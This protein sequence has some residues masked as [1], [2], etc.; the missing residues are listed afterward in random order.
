MGQRQFKP[1]ET[2]ESV[3]V[4]QAVSRLD[5]DALGE[6][7][8][9]A[10]DHAGELAAF[11][12]GHTAA[13]L[14]A[15]RLASRRSRHATLECERLAAVFDVDPDSIRGADAMIASHLTPPADAAEIRT[16]RRHLIVTEEL[17]TAVRSATQPRPN[18]RPALAAAA[19]W[20]LGRA[21]QATTRPDD[22]AIGLDERALRTHA[23]RIRRDLELARLG[24]KL[25]ALVVEER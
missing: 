6:V 9:T 14:G 16:L 19:P 25:H 23:A 2:A 5:V 22:D 7:A 4:E 11:E 15:I 21:E 13:V 1:E 3:S 20:L 12:F 17:L 8:G 10:F 24:T 18:C